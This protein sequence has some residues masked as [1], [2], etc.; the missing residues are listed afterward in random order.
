VNGVRIVRRAHGVPARQSALRRARYE[1]SFLQ[2][3]W[4]GREIGSVEAVVG[5]VPTL[6]A[7]LLARVHGAR[8][9][10][11]YG[12]IFQDLMGPASVQSGIRGGASWVGALAS[13]AE[14]WSVRRA[15]AVAA[16]SRAFFPYLRAIGVADDRLVHLP[17]WSH[18]P[19]AKGTPSDIRRQ[20]GWP[21]HVRVVLHAGNMG[22][23]QDLGQVIEAARLVAQNGTPI[24]FVLLGDGSQRRALE[25]AA[26]G[27][28]SVE[29]GPSLPEQAYADALAAADVLLVSERPSVV[30]MALPS[31]LT[32][33]LAS[34]RPVVAAVHPSG[35]TADE[36]RRS[37]GGLVVAPGDPAALVAAIERLAIEPALVARLA[38]AGRAYAAEVLAEASALERIR[39]FVDRVAASAGVRAMKDRPALP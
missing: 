36:V 20:L 32:S 5:I 12:L 21:A 38:A 27:L 18:L 13:R 22:L 14:R 33:Y 9:H 4:S 39:S 25:V 35:T 24:R 2:A 17:N 16:V 19:H 7:G 3:G 1:A 15:S 6:S 37:G 11:P 8:R 10:A 34:G 29:F 28:A 26:A 31:K 23:K 30:D